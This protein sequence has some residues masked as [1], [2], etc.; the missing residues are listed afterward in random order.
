VDIVCDLAKRLGVADH[1][2]ND[3]GELYDE[4]IRPAGMSFPEFKE[5]KRLF[6]PFVYRQYERKGFN[7]LS[8]KIE[9]YSSLLAKQGCAPLPPF[10]DPFVGPGDSPELATEYPYI[11]T[12]GWRQSVYRHTENR[13]NPLLREIHPRPSVLIH[14]ATAATLNI[15]EGDPLRIETPTGHATLF[16]VFTLG[17]HPEVVQTTPGWPGEAN[18]NRVIPWDRFAEGVGSVPMRGI[19]CR[20]GRGSAAADRKND[21]VKG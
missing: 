17:I 20:I 12:T 13:E 21:E 10:T 4:L 18:I 11:L 1:F 3:A 19:R 5:K 7:T 14:P 16:A 15:A 9:L 8:G 6:A 2:W